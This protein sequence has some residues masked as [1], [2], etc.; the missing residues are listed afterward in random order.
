MALSTDGCEL[1]CPTGP[2]NQMEVQ[3]AAKVSSLTRVRAVSSSGLSGPSMLE[4][5]GQV[6]QRQGCRRA[7]IEALQQH[8]ASV[9]EADAVTM[10]TASVGKTNHLHCF[11]GPDV[12]GA[13]HRLI[14][15]FEAKAGTRRHANS[16]GAVRRG[17]EA[18]SAR[19]M[20]THFG[21]DG[22]VLRYWPILLPVGWDFYLR[23]RFG[24]D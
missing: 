15:T 3:Q 22:P 6:T 17:D 21:P 10:G 5:F 20:T 8:L 9:R 24:T 13:R 4:E 18:R 7:D 23:T 14:A 12:Q 2:F 1:P 16:G 19:D 11:G